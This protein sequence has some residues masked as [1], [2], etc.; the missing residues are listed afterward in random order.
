MTLSDTPLY[1]E[2][3]EL[4][5]CP[6]VTNVEKSQKEG[7]KQIKLRK[8]TSQLLRI[9]L[10]KKVKGIKKRQRTDGNATPETS[11]PSSACSCQLESLDDFSSCCNDS[12]A[13]ALS[14]A[15]DGALYTTKIENLNET[16]KL[17]VS[18]TQIDQDKR[19]EHP[20]FLKKASTEDIPLERPPSLVQVAVKIDRNESNLSDDSSGDLQN[21][22]LIHPD[23]TA[24][25]KP[26]YEDA[27][28]ILENWSSASIIEKHV[29]LFG[30][31]V[32]ATAT[33]ATH[34]VLFLA[35][36]IGAVWSVGLYHA[37]EQGYDY[38]NDGTFTNFFWSEHPDDS[39]NLQFTCEKDEMQYYQERYS[40]ARHHAKEMDRFID[41]LYGGINGISLHTFSLDKDSEN[42]VDQTLPD[43]RCNGLVPATFLED[44]DEPTLLDKTPASSGLLECEQMPAPEL[45]EG[46]PLSESKEHVEFAIT[47]EHLTKYFPP[48]DSIVVK[49]VKFPGIRGVEIFDIF[50][51][52]DAPF[53]FIEFQKN[54]G[55]I[56]IL[57]SDWEV[58]SIG[59]KFTSGHDL[60]P[61]PGVVSSERKCSYKTLTKSYFGP[62]YCKVNS[63]QRYTLVND[64]LCYL[65]V[66]SNMSEVPLSDRFYIVERWKFQSQFGNDVKGRQY[67]RR[68]S[69]TSSLPMYFTNVSV[70]CELRMT[71]SCS[72]EKQIRQRCVST[73]SDI[74]DAWCK[75]AVRALKL[76]NEKKMERL[77]RKASVVSTFDALCGIN[78]V[79]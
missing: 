78:S 57:Y 28:L 45:S 26:Y 34:P 46:N 29:P 31:T 59:A 27:D 10:S 68:S 4:Q 20:P 53:S 8:T 66:K 51:S 40:V 11:S 69:K 39:K 50:L 22:A 55:D 41:P 1:A 73:V 63:V 58:P 9:V 62:T 44:Q 30:L 7:P 5:S 37:V 61:L 67:G 47:S 13:S 23:T 71:R 35:G 16:L 43:Y 18:R 75:R 64:D 14:N 32:V 12:S 76:A 77:K 36:T 49:N 74:G 6:I 56:D 15:S 25:Y 52:D 72:W 24:T 17:I 60:A 48:F 38:F 2:E 54:R 42:N 70:E 33:V 21:A 65:E 79:L 19:I 3:F